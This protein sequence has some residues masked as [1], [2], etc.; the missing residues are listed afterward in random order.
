VKIHF[1]GAAR[2]VTGSRHLIELDGLKI[3]LDC[4]LYQGKRDEANKINRGFQ[5]DPAALDLVVLS[6]AHID[7]SG[8]LPRLVKSGFRGDIICTEAT[9]DLADIM[10]RDSAHIQE[11]DIEYLNRKRE[12]NNLPPLEPLYTTEDA[13]KTVG[14]LSG[15]PYGRRR[16][17]APGVSVTFRDAGHILGSAFVELEIEKNGNGK[18]VRLVFSGDLGRKNR[19]IL[20]DPE[21][22]AEAD[23]LIIESTY[24]DRLHEHKES[25][26]ERLASIINGAWQ[27]GGKVIVPAF[28]VGRTQEI[29]YALHQLIS[30]KK[31]PENLPVYVDS[32]LATEAT[33]VYRRHPEDWDAETGAFL[34]H[35]GSSDPFGF[36]RLRYTRTREESMKLNELKGPAVI[37][38]A[39]GM[40]EAG[41]I[42]H[43]LKHNIGDA[44]NTMLFVGF[45]AQNTLGRRLSEGA[46]KARIFG[47]EHAVKARIEKIDGLSAHADR[48]ELLDWVGGLTRRPSRVFVV[49]GEETASLAFAA[50][51]KGKGFPS[52]EVPFKDD[53]REIS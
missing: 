51:L 24:G 11:Q 23:V 45:Q 29:V 6:H 9:L 7:H 40:A 33:G 50:T 14:R 28:A 36:P 22:C 38:S 47:V 52:V 15:T 53:M 42:L 10:L 19:P 20:R 18:P 2:T 34:K 31:I 30:A 41:R 43:H 44:R 8:N 13:E 39:S 27:R 48:D 17:L 5:F 32:P 4:G 21:V 37:I 12:R 26:A 49:H 35:D 46:P 3:L 16:T 25:G 1:Y